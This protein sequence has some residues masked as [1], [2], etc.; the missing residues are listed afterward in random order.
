MSNRRKYGV[1]DKVTSPTRLP[2]RSRPPI[3]A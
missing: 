2:P 1:R 3:L